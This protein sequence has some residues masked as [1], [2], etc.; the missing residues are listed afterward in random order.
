MDKTQQNHAPVP[1]PKRFTSLIHISSNQHKQI[2]SALSRQTRYQAPARRLLG[3][4]ITLSATPNMSG[5]AY[6]ELGTRLR[7]YKGISGNAAAAKDSLKIFHVP[8]KTVYSNWP[9]AQTPLHY[10]T[11]VDFSANSGMLAIGNDRGKVLLYRLKHY[12][13]V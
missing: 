12:H 1:W 3:V 5:I 4:G 8:S 11:S 7:L 6:D 10:V 9:T 13:S 2:T